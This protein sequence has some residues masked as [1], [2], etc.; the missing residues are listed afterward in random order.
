MTFSY[1][2]QPDSPPDIQTIQKQMAIVAWQP[3]PNRIVQVPSEVRVRPTA[4]A[5]SAC[6]QQAGWMSLAELVNPAVRPVQSFG[7][8]QCSDPECD[9][10]ITYM[11]DWLG[12]AHTASGASLWVTPPSSAA[13][14]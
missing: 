2:T 3:G 4:A 9:L 7:M 10:R 6:M 1:R 13:L 11:L 8:W 14:L 5:V 12:L